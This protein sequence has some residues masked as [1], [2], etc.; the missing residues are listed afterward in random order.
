MDVYP[1]HL[2]PGVTEALTN[3]TIDD[4]NV[5]LKQRTISGIWENEG[6]KFVIKGYFFSTSSLLIR[7]ELP[8]LMRNVGFKE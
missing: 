5:A 4:Q 1:A 7:L 8:N 6:K 2:P 3:I